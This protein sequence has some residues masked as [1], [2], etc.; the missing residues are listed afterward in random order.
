[1]TGAS[2]TI[3]ENSFQLY[4]AISAAEP[5]ICRHCTTEH[6]RHVLHPGAD[7][8][9]VRRQPADDAAELG[10][11]EKRHRHGHELAEQIRPH[12]VHHRLAQFERE[13]LAEMERQHR[14][15]AKRK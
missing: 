14:A 12:V 13:P 7:A 3:S 8:V 6:E 15:S 1:M 2:M 10:P 4:H 5:A 9:N 11:V